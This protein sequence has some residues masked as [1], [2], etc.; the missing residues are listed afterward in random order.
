VTPPLLAAVLGT[1]I[2]QSLSPVIHE[3]A[4]RVAGRIGRYAAIECSEVEFPE[5]VRNV[6][7]R[8]ALGVSVT[9]PCKEVAARTCDSLDVNADHLG[10]VNCIHFDDGTLRGY[11]TDGD[12][13]CDALV[14][15][16]E[17]VI[18][19][20]RAL[21]LGAGGTA[22]SVAL[23][24]ARRGANVLI[25]NRTR[26]RADRAVSMLAPALGTIGGIGVGSPADIGDVDI[27]VNAT[28]VGMGTDESPVDASHLSARLVVLDAVYHP[29][30][31]RLLRDARQAGARC[32][33]GLWM[34][35]HQ[36]RRQQSIWLG[37]L[38][39]IEP[40]RVESERVLR[41]RSN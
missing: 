36:A 35:I 9:M 28:S 13:C 7:S 39:D 22:R 31:T 1:P 14:G 4:F 20:S 38:P 25:V 19:G 11:N 40:M 10:A 2:S 5:T 18:E 26:Q 3:A 6:M 29:L 12:G 33:D 17:C 23:A 8:G 15:E 34:L 41:A 24:L 32:V 21:V 27:L 30:E 37:T 16:A